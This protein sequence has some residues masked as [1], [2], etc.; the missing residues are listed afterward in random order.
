MTGGV[1]V[2]GRMTISR[3][4]AA[5]CH[6][7]FLTS[8]EMD[9]RITNLHALGALANLRLLNRINSIE[10]RAAAISHCY[11]VWGCWRMPI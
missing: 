5:K 7:A 2:L 11:C 6:S 3:I 1:G 8:A 10:M 9:P 4:V